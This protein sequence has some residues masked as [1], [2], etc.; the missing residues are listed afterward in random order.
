M[1]GIGLFKD[2]RQLEFGVD[3]HFSVPCLSV[4]E[5]E[6]GHQPRRWFLLRF[7]CKGGS[8]VP[9]SRRW[10]QICLGAGLTDL[11]FHDFML[12]VGSHVFGQQVDGPWIAICKHW[13]PKKGETRMN[14][15]RASH[16][17]FHTPQK[18]MLI[19]RKCHFYKDYYFAVVMKLLSGCGVVWSGHPLLSRQRKGNPPFLVAPT[20]VEINPYRS[21]GHSALPGAS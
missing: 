11:A 17:S 15:R 9:Q 3:G 10:R 16:R 2:H 14:T 5:R 1:H 20:P 7:F 8:V 6:L 21:G 13:C 12:V 18:G 4:C 19:C